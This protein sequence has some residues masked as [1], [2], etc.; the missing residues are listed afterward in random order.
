MVSQPPLL[1]PSA[2]ISSPPRKLLLLVCLFPRCCL[3]PQLFSIDVSQLS[4]FPFPFLPCGLTGKL[5]L[6][7][8]LSLS[9]CA[10]RG[11][12][13]P[14]SQGPKDRLWFLD[15]TNDVDMRQTRG[16]LHTVRLP[17]TQETRQSLGRLC[18]KRKDKNSDKSHLP[19]PE[20]VHAIAAPCAPHR[21][22]PTKGAVRGVAGQTT[23][24]INQGL[25]DPV[26][27]ARGCGRNY[28]ARSTHHGITPLALHWARAY[29]STTCG[30]SGSPQCR[31]AHPLVGWGPSC[32]D[33]AV[34]LCP[35]ASSGCLTGV[36]R[37]RH[38]YHIW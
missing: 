15:R 33:Q 7:L 30:D 16:F 5:F 4:A 9:R 22:D 6:L 26:C 11:T 13:L 17:S 38:Q 35:T 23:A 24:R 1:N 34:T 21:H 19:Q 29:A 25:P 36:I 28:F 37:V 8:C 12:R 31:S 32:E 14:R 27:H 18:V 2:L 20:A 10:S 3:T